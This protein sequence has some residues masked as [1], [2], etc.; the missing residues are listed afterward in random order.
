MTEIGRS[1]GGAL[2]A[3]ARDEQLSEQILRELELL[4]GAFAEN[5]DFVR[6]LASPALPKKERVAILD[7]SFAGSVHPY[8]LNFLKILT[9]NGTIREFSSCVNEYRRQYHADH[10]ILPVTAVTAI[11]L[12]ETL[13]TRLCEKLAAVTGKKIELHERVESDVLGGIR[14][15]T[16]GTMLDGTARKRLDDLRALL[17]RT[18]LSDTQEAP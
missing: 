2:Y 16:D 17:K 3:L 6:L 18:V 11:P 4:R 5:E 12:T 14:L 9:E 1:Y 15:Q 10:G 8:T 13:R 7:E